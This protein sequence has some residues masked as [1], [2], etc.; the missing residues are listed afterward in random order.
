LLPPAPPT[1][2]SWPGSTR[3]HAAKP[4]LGAPHLWR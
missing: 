4:P 3:Q 1:G 2:N